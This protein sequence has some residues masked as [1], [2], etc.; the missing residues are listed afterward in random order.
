MLAGEWKI[1]DGEWKTGVK[2]DRNIMRLIFGGQ[3]VLSTN[4][5]VILSDTVCVELMKMPE[6]KQSGQQ[7]SCAQSQGKPVF[8]GIWSECLTEGQSR[9]VI[10]RHICRVLVLDTRKDGE[11]GLAIG[12][13][14]TSVWRGVEGAVTER[15]GGIWKLQISSL[16]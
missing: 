13:T 11:A 6:T 1:N 9:G 2:F 4:P 7:A 10:M 14:F 8:S 12:G 5:V 3:R 16:F 15:G